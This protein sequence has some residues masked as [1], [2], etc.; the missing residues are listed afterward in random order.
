MGNKFHETGFDESKRMYIV[1]D[2]DD[3]IVFQAPKLCEMLYNEYK[4]R[5]IT[6]RGNCDADVDQ[7][8]VDFAIT[9]PYMILPLEGG[10][11]MVL[12]HGHNPIEDLHI[13]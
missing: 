6:V 2:I 9:A 5:I 3:V 1:C 7:M 10:H 13:Q 11:R 4:D 8:M 12:T